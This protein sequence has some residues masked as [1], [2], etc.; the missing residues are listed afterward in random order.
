MFKRKIKPEVTFFCSIYYQNKSM[1]KTPSNNQG[2]CSIRKL[3]REHLFK[4]GISED[5][6]SEPDDKPTKPTKKKKSNKK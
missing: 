1:E 4:Y 5:F 2:H 3:V 6:L